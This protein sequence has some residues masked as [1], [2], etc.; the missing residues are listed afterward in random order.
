MK[1]VSIGITVYNQAHYI[2]QAVESALAQDYPNLEVVVSDNY[3][4]DAID[5]AMNKYLHDSRVKYFRN[6]QN[7]GMIAN[8]RKALYEYSSGELALHL[9]GDDFLI[10]H[11]YISKAVDLLERHQL[12]MVFSRL[13]SF[14]EKENLFIEDKVNGNLPKIIDGNWFFLNFYKGYSLPTLTVLH[15]RRKA[16]EIGFFEKDIR[17]SDWECFLRLIV[18]HKIGFIDE[19]VGVWRRHGQNE[20]MKQ[21][22][23]KLISNVEYVE[24]PLRYVLS[25]EIFSKAVAEKWRR[26]MLKR[27]FAKIL[28]TAVIIKNRE[29]EKKISD[30]LR[31]YDIRIYR[32]LRGDIRFRVLMLMAENQV[33]IRFVFKYVFG[34]E[35]FARDFE[36]MR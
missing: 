22:F 16:M 19:F 12:V 23:D 31:Q 25:K 24:S 34:Q 2:G 28:V 15:D 32:A 7:I 30:H 35:S 21:D 20:T 1:K 27:Y 17:S 26:L 29:L 33:L 10:D 8:A 3:S 36:Y 18:T 13:K 6:E 11:R 5:L 9:D 4:T 14:Y